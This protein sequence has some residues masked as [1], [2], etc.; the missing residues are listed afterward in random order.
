M[1]KPSIGRKLWFWETRD[2]FDA[3]RNNHFDHDLLSV[4]E[5]PLDAT[6]VAVWSP[7]MINVYV[8]DHGGVGRAETSVQ[9]IQEGDIIPEGRFATWMPFQVGQARAQAAA[10]S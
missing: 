1:I 4:H 9:L 6:V 8:I 3:A 2:A 7:T 10:A 5:Q